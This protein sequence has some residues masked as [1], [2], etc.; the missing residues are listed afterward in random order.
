MKVISDIRLYKSSGLNNYISFTDKSLNLTVR[1]IVMKL[2]EQEYSLGE[3]DHLYLNFTTE[4]PEETIFLNNTADQYHPWFRYCDIG[5]SQADYDKLGSAD[6][7]D[8]IIT[9]IESVLLNCFQASDTTGQ[10][11]KSSIFQALKGPEM[12][13]RFKEKKFA[14]ATV[15]IFLR[16]PDSG[17][18]APLLC[19][20]D[21]NGNVILR[22]DL[23]ETIDL[24]IIGEIK[25]NSKAVMIK[26]RKNAFTKRQDPISFELDM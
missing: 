24:S 2:R 9:Q 25:L 5:V 21:L 26:P 17:L 13:M 4:R 19:V 6:C 1:R 16:F 22:A 3:F 23:P 18:Y 8:Y 12:L 15:T 7:T 11:V 10:I 20:A 14:K